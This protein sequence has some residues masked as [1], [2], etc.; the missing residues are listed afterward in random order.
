MSSLRFLT[1]TTLK[2]VERSFLL[3]VGWREF[4]EMYKYQ[5]P[6]SAGRVLFQTK[7]PLFDS[8]IKIPSLTYIEQK[9]RG[10][11]TSRSLFL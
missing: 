2:V 11:S 5:Y 7:G 8:N 6:L 4:E 1:G 10:L 3:W 9:D